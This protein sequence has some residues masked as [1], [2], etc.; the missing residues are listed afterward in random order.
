MLEVK[1]RGFILGSVQTQEADLILRIITSEGEKLSFYARSAL[2]SRK[3]FEGGLR[4]LTQIEYRGKKKESSQLFFLEESKIT[5]DFP[6]LVKWIESLTMAS[7]FAELVDKTAQEGLENTALYNLFGA[8]L[9]SLN[10]GSSPWI[11]CPAF[12]FKLL[13]LLGWLPHAE[14]LKES[15][16]GIL[17]KILMTPLGDTVLSLEEAHRVAGSSRRLIKTHLGEGRIKTLEFFSSLLTFQEKEVVLD[18]KISA[19]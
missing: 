7:Y 11:M 14:D 2:K 17:K 3:R 12:E 1:G 15:E 5:H 9:K 13:A 10:A 6:S 4:P 19:N 18:P 16:Q 8:A